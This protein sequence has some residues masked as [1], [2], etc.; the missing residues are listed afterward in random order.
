MTV[1]IRATHTQKVT[2]QDT[3][4][5][6]F[7]NKPVDVTVECDAVPAIPAVTATDNC[8]QDVV[9]TFNEVRTDGTCPDSYIL[10]RSWVALDNCGNAT[11]HV[12][13][14]TVRD[15]KSPVFDLKPADVTVECDAVPTPPV[16]TATDNCDINVTVT[17]TEIRT[18]GTCPDSYV[19]TRTW[20]A[21]DNCD[22]PT[23]HVQKVTVRDTQAPIFLTTPSDLYGEL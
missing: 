2:V 11:T 3:K 12:Q 10:S 5:P 1:T 17:Y 9:V 19:L 13:K 14:V 21:I 8:D 18:D 16:V 22:N 7:T 6:V 15:T 4:P 23:T 20:V